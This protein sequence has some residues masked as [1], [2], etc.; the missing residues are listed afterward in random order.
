MLLQDG[1]GRN[2]L[3]IRFARPNSPED[4][5]YKENA[6]GVMQHQA[7][8]VVTDVALRVVHELMEFYVIFPRTTEFPGAALCMVVGVCH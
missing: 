4:L 3:P 1:A 7:V 5:F 2:W 8:T 6:P